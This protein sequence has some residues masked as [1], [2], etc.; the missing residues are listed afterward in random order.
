MT[1]VIMVCSWT[2]SMRLPNIPVGNTSTLIRM[3]KPQL[4]EFIAGQYEL[5][6]GNYYIP[7][8]EKYYAYPD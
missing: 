6:G 8:L 7:G 4:N 2:I 3:G 5:M 1:V